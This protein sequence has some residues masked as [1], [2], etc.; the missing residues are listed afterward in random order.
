MLVFVLWLLMM[1]CVHVTEL[2][3][4]VLKFFCGSDILID[5]NLYFLLQRLCPSL[6]VIIVPIIS[7]RIPFIILLGLRDLCLLLLLIAL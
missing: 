4:F 7:N 6:S 3:P 2:S 5:Y 1:S